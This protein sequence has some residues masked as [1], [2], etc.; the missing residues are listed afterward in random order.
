MIKP[1]SH[2]PSPMKPW[3]RTT[4]SQIQQIESNV[5]RIQSVLDATSTNIDYEL[6]QGLSNTFEFTPLED[7]STQASAGDI[8]FTGAITS[9][10]DIS[11]AGTLLVGDPARQ[12]F[13][14]TTGDAIG[15][16]PTLE[17]VAGE[18]QVNPITEV[19]YY[20][21]GQINTTDTSFDLNGYGLITG[22]GMQLTLSN[23]G[24][25]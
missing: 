4:D 12:E 2:A 1:E 16:I 10:S 24:Q 14:P 9:E 25:V 6:N 19:E 22:D 15:S 11:V 7:G 5:A 13:D 23:N 3:V 17:V 20:T 8:N 18:L 21:A